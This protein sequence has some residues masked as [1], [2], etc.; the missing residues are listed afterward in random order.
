M[1]GYLSLFATGSVPWNQLSEWR[2]HP[3]VSWHSSQGSVSWCSGLLRPCNSIMSQRNYHGQDTWW[4]MTHQSAC[5][6][7]WLFPKFS[8]PSVLFYSHGDNRW[9]IST[10]KRSSLLSQKNESEGEFQILSMFSPLSW[11]IFILQWPPWTSVFSVYW[12]IQEF[13]GSHVSNHF[14]VCR[15]HSVPR[16]SRKVCCRHANPV[17][18]IRSRQLFWPYNRQNPR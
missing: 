3:F 13:L 18:K 4:S 11:F 17:C 6:N 15:S 7:C 2:T 16:K 8:L 12:S 1:Q 14:I 5:F 9:A 10:I